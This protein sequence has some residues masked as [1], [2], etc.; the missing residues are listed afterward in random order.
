MCMQKKNVEI[1]LQD[2]NKPIAV[3]DYELIVPKKELQ[4]LVLEEMNRTV[5]DADEKYE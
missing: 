4:T 3:A 5:D 1:A 2:I